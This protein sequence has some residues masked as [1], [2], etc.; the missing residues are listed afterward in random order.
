MAA[1]RAPAS[2]KSPPASPRAP[3][4][5]RLRFGQLTEAVTTMGNLAATP[6]VVKLDMQ[7]AVLGI[8]YRF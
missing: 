4:V 2:L 6:A 3:P 1:G 8:N 7:T 5:D